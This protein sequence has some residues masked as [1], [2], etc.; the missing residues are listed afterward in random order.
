[1]RR[2]SDTIARLAAEQA[3]RMPSSDGV[4]RLGDRTGFGRNPGNL[5]ARVY[6][7][8]TVPARPALVVVLHGCTQT[9]AG[10]DA[11]SGW[12]QLADAQ[13]FVLLFPEQQRANN[14][15]L[16]FNW[17]A[18]EDVSHDHGEAFSIRE[19]IAAV[20][21]DHDVD[22]AR[23]FVTGLSAGGAMAAVML[24]TYPELFAGGAILGGLPYGTASGVMQALER[25]RGQNMPD[26]AALGRLAHQA[27]RHGGGWPTLS[28]WH[29]DADATVDPVNA[30]ALLTQ[31][32]ALHDL[33]AE[34]AIRT[35]EGQR[36]YRGWRDAGGR[37]VLEDH[38]IHGMGH[39]TP[40]AAHGPEACGMPAP[41]MLD[42]GISSTRRIA[43]FWGLAP[44]LSTGEAR[45]RLTRVTPPTPQRAGGVAGVINDALRAAGLLR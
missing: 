15:N 22:P 24:A 6:V 38:R 14:P 41:F 32:R 1:M 33:S 18:P 25:M 3:Q 19:M 44:A 34:P 35:S 42:V 29:G 5:R 12:S 36:A 30:E 8:A 10:Y 23:V 16:C 4:D 20:S 40:I 31:W 28:V 39:G 45:P 27:S 26:A 43:A 21:A 7:P 11:G 17:F 9:A 13:G 2:L 37:L